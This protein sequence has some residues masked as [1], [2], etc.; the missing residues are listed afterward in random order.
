[1]TVAVGSSALRLRRGFTLV[2][3]VIGMTIFSLIAG[4][5]FGIIFQ[6][7]SEAA[8]IRDMEARDQQVSRF[9]TLLRESLE[10]LPMEGSVALVNDDETI[11]GWPELTF[12]DVPTA[13][14]F[15]VN[16]G[17]AGET[18]IG[19]RPVTQP[20]P[21]LEGYTQPLFN[22][23]LSRELSEGDE[24]ESGM[25]LRAGTDDL[26][27]DEDEEGRRWLPLVENVTAL[28]WRYWNAE[29]LLWVEMDDWTE[30]DSLPS[31][32][33]MTLAD[34]FR[35]PLRVV[36][37]IPEHATEPAEDGGDDDSS[38][39]TGS[40]T[41]APAPTRSTVGPAARGPAPGTRPDGGG[42]DGGGKGGRPGG[43]KGGPGGGKGGPGGGAKGGGGGGA[44]TGGSGG[45]PSGG[46]GGS[47]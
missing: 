27:V 2:E 4:S 15:G 18:I 39:D 21:Q 22:I 8:A 7:G 9:V 33:E 43:G 13:F 3:V 42:R 6:A 36:F 24:N 16:P 12:A 19:L 32:L 14:V 47:R 25:N 37:Q 20:L 5:I 35:P 45:A 38:S 44:G 1:M 26:F 29:D 40:T 28:G 11:S 10:A 46:G 30:G 34:P 41:A 17:T 31:L 23:A